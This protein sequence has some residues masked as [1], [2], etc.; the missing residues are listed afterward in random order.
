MCIKRLTPTNSISVVCFFLQISSISF[1]FFFLAY[2][3]VYA[4]VF[5]LNVK[6]V[7]SSFIACHLNAK[8]GFLW[9][10]RH[11]KRNVTVNC[12]CFNLKFNICVFCDFELLWLH[13][14]RLI[15]QSKIAFSLFIFEYNLVIYVEGW[16]IGLFFCFFFYIVYRY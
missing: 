4:V 15:L 11:H 7:L 12:G 6:L 14:Y 16:L 2:Q 5:V 13:L 1:S 9:C 10:V 3:K 8:F